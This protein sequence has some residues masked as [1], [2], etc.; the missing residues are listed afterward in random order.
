MRTNYFGREVADEVAYVVSSVFAL[1]NGVSGLQD[2]VWFLRAPWTLTEMWL[3]LLSQNIPNVIA[4]RPER[5]EVLAASTD[6][7]LITQR[8]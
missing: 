6:I 7:H 1:F 2:D 4:K 3:V 5:F 8:A